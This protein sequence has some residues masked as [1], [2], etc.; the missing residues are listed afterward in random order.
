MS[1]IISEELIKISF[2]KGGITLNLDGYEDYIFNWPKQPD[3]ILVEDIPNKNIR[4]NDQ[5]IDFYFQKKQ[6]WIL[7]RRRRYI[8]WLW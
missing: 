4:N 2:K 1:N 7:L 8:I 5:K 3:L 6:W